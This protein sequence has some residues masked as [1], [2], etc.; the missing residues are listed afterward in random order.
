MPSDLHPEEGKGP[1]D[2]PLMGTFR[3]VVEDSDL[4]IYQ[5]A[6]LIGTSGAILSMWLAGTAKPN[7]AELAKIESFLGR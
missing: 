6:S 2:E 7:K 1:S 4:S 5:I 3:R